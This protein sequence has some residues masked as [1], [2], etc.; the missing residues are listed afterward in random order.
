MDSTAIL[1]MDLRP[2][3]L[4]MGIVLWALLN[5][6]RLVYEQEVSLWYLESI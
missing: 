1:R 2:R 6:H 4:Y 5:P 3:I